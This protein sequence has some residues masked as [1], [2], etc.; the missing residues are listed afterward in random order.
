MS[1]HRA[2]VVAEAEEDLVGVVVE[3]PPLLIAAV[4]MAVV[5]TREI[6]ME[7]EEGIAALAVTEEAAMVVIVVVH[8]P[9]TV[10]GRKNTP[11]YFA[12]F[13]TSN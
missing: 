12:F 8:L 2:E 3:D 5:G 6:G 1:H 11:R 7:G 13:L 4:V 10:V 9:L